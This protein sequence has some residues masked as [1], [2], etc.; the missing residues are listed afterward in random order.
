M[1]NVLKKITKKY[2]WLRFLNY[3]TTKLAVLSA[4][5]FGLCLSSGASFAKYRD[6][7]YGG[8]NAGAA[9][10]GDVTISYI[11]DDAVTTINLPKEGSSSSEDNPDVGWHAF[12]ATFMMTIRPS[13]VKRAISLSIK[14]GSIND[15]SF[16]SVST[17][18]KTTFCMS[19]AV[20]TE[21]L[22]TYCTKENDSQASRLS[23]NQA[24]TDKVGRWE[25]LDYS[26]ST[27]K[28]DCLYYGVWGDNSIL[29]LGTKSYNAP[30]DVI[31][32]DD[33]VTNNGYKWIERKSGET[34]TIINKDGEEE[35]ITI[36]SSN[37]I[38]FD[39]FVLEPNTTS[40]DQ[41]IFFKVLFFS[42]FEI[43][44][45]KFITQTAKIFYE[46]EVKQV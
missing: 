6:E 28:K 31:N 1:S 37:L 41:M 24:R 16:E 15:S 44:N 25:H 21:N 38:T 7:N 13:E 29:P 42:D 4:A 33:S 34:K 43:E 11:E 39:D 5:L 27:F 30:I 35:E 2:K 46:L 3:K 45:K 22:T 8:G 23:I 32:A 17:L 40:S 19:E 20:A 12:I 36:I 9:T 18:D 10:F 14:L 26:I